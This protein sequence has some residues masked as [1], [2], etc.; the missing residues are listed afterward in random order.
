VTL[1]K[2]REQIL[3]YIAMYVCAYSNAPTAQQIGNVFGISQQAAHNHVKG[4][5]EA[6]HLVA[7]PDRGYRLASKI[8]IPSV[9]SIDSARKD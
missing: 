3:I 2:R 9:L 6:G 8:Y 5:I 1:S 4:L 7:L